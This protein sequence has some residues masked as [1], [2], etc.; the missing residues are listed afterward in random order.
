MRYDKLYFNRLPHIWRLEQRKG[1]RK[2]VH[3]LMAILAFLI[4][5]FTFVLLQQTF[6]I[7]VFYIFRKLLI[8]GKHL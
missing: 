2:V 7:K 5:M 3:F 8:S 1:P 4:F 6:L